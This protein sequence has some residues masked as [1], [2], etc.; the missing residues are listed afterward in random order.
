MFYVG[1][2]ACRNI[3]GQAIEE[4]FRNVQTE[5]SNCP[6]AAPHLPTHEGVEG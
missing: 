4:G 6:E 1:C 5:V 3:H 2:P